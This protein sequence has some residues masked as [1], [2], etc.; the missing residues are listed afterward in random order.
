MS[1]ESD[2]R[3]TPEPWLAIVRQFGDGVIALD[4][5]TEA[6]NPTRAN[7][8]Y[9][10]ALGV[11]GLKEPWAFDAAGGLA[12]GNVP[13]SA[14]QVIRWSQKAAVEA[15]R[16]CEILL[17][18]KDDCRTKWNRFLRENADAR[19][20]AE[21]SLGFAE[22]DGAGGYKQNPAP[23]WGSC[24]WYFGRRRRRF[25]L[26]FSAIGEVIHGLGPVEPKVEVHHG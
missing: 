13:Y 16:G 14:G 17:L 2:I 21:R 19:C 24:F 3:L 12:W 20:R 26:V 8:F 5:C 1:K 18:T 22:P 10:L 11:D 6:D 7:V 9:S 23:A 15:R 25:E 4:V